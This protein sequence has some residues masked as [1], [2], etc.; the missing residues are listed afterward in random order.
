VK[1]F[2]FILGITSILLLI[3]SCGGRPH[4]S[5]AITFY[6]FDGSTDVIVL[7]NEYLG[8]QFFPETTGI[9]LTDKA[10]GVEWRS[11]PAEQDQF[12][13]L[14]VR[15][16]QNSQFALEFANVNGIGQVQ[17][18]GE[19]SVNLGVYEFNVENGVLEV[20]YTV[21]NIERTY[22]IPPAVPEYRMLEFIEDMTQIQRSLI[23]AGYRLY[24][25]NNLRRDDNR[26]ELLA[27]YPDLARHKVYVLSTAIREYQK[28]E[29]EIYFAEAGYTYEDYL[30]DIAHY[31][32]LAIAERPTFNITM[33]YYLDGKSLMVDIPFDKIAYRPSFPITYL[34]ILPFFGAGGV[35]DEGYLLIPDG[36]GAIINFNNG[37][38]NQ[39][40][41]SSFIYGWDEGLTREV[42]ISDNR[43]PFPAFGIQKNGNAFVCIIENGAS[44][45]SVRADVSGRNSSYNHVFPRFTMVHSELMN[46]SGRSQRDVYQFERSLPEG[47]RIT[48]RYIICAEDTYVGMAKEYRSWLLE[49]YP[50]LR[51]NQRSESRVPVAVEIV[52]AVNKTQ[53]ILGIPF[54]LPLRLTSYNEVEEI[55]QDFSGFGWRN[56]HIKLNGWF[57]H[58]VDHSIPTRFR[59]IR[60]LG[61]KN[62]FRNMVEA[63]NKNGYGFYPEVDFFFM[64]DKRPFDGFNLYRDASR[65]I[66]RQRIQRYPYSFVWFGERTYWGKLSY[67]A[68]PEVMMSL[69]DNFANEKASLGLENIAF[70]NI[71]SRLAGDY[72]ERRHVSREASMRMRQ[73]KLDDLDRSGTGIMLLAGHAYAMPWA[74]FIIDLPLSD[75]SFGITDYSVP[76][77]SIARS[78]LVPFTGRAI[79]LAEDYTKNLLKIIESGA[80]LYFSFMVEETAALQETKFRQFYAN[81]YHKWVGDANDLYRR[82]TADFGHLFNQAIVGHSVL[83]RNVTVTEYEDGTSVVVNASDSTWDYNG[84]IIRADSYI[85]LR[86][87]E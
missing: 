3:N 81:E 6:E 80:G 40:P 72:N 31:P 78:G 69:I 60:Q 43:S 82:F 51:R 83:S 64:R 38:N 63:A 7:D 23:N 34:N 18:S 49:R 10:T 48:L 28:A 62:D 26:D 24:D 37:K 57:N 54:D 66:N 87:G 16:M 42:V 77:Y 19:H 32:A 35:N 85:V 33:R 56:V 8:L 58:S 27:L 75:Q 52:G 1:K 84:R 17:Y 25:I 39:L 59:L 21:G 22:I 5:R 45:A 9:V 61:S 15:H 50:S 79:N 70:R 20:N 36:N 76:F 4:A 73:D 53:H 30:E 29:Y 65:Y 46:I 71:G 12:A 41:F 67:V 13:D 14:V 11:N 44:Y 47:E 74:D 55:I 68:R 86:Q 2:I